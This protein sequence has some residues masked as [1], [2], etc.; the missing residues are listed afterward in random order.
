M[1]REVAS[2]RSNGLER[3]E[4]A[5]GFGQRGQRDYVAGLRIAAPESKDGR[6][7]VRSLDRSRRP[8]E[9]LDDGAIA[10]FAG[11]DRAVGRKSLGSQNRNMFA[12]QLEQVA[13]LPG[14]GL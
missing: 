5:G 10:R 9:N 14:F 7:G 11:N 1:R 2:L 8:L 12:G 6:I 13:S 4:H 3:S